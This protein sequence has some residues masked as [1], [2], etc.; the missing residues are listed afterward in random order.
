MSGEHGSCKLK[1]FQRD[2]EKTERGFYNAPGRSVSVSLRRKK[3]ALEVLQ[4]QF[5]LYLMEWMT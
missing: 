1:K 2:G 3:Q 5:T 4:L